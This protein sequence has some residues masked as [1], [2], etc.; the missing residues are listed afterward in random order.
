MSALLEKALEAI[1]RRTNVSTGL[2]HPNDMNAAKEMFTRLHAAGE[3]LLAE[4]ISAWA[5]MN[6]WQKKDAEQ[7]G[8]LAQQIGMGKK[9][10]I[11]DG[12]WW[13]DGILEI[14]MKESN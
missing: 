2:T 4:E 10:R 7:L 11:S 12:P 3:I 1:H 6:G 5:E 8:A 13:K 9:V 14:L